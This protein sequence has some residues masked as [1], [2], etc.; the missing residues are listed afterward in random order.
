MKYKP[1][2]G[3]SAFL[4]F[5][6]LMGCNGQEFSTDLGS[7]A[8]EK[9]IACT[10]PAESSTKS[11]VQVSWNANRET[12]VNKAG[13]GYRIYYCNNSGYSISTVTTSFVDVN[14]VSG[15]TAPIT[16][17]LPNLNNG[18][19]YIKVVAFSAL[20]PPGATNGS[21]SLASSEFS[22]TVP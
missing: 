2:W 3:K 8:P 17:L 14:Y 19:Y 21:S 5:N 9:I 4:F 6:I 20:T 22:I 12:A 10:L 11:R 7:V 13:G 18:T 1:F 15:P 16:A